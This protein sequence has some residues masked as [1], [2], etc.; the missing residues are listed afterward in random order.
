MANEPVITVIGNLT[1]DPTIR[2]TQKGDAVANF[3]VASTPRTF[4]STKNQWVDGEPLFMNCTA[5]RNL[6]QNIADSLTKGTRVIVTGRL[7]SRSYQDRDGNN[8]RSV[9]VEVEEAG[10]SLMFATVQINR[11]GGGS[12]FSQPQQQQQRQDADPWN[13]AGQTQEPPF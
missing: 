4:D 8:R 10:A 7:K 1:T 2:F 11:A 6:A 5:W 9:E 13:S 3:T 12:N